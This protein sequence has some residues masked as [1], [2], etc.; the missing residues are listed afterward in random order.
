VKEHDDGRWA[1]YRLVWLARSHR[2]RGV[3]WCRGVDPVQLVDTWRGSTDDPEWRPTSDRPSGPALTVEAALAQP[4]GSGLTDPM[5]SQE[6]I[7]KRIADLQ[8]G[9]AGASAPRLH[10]PP[11]RTSVLRHPTKVLVEAD[12][13]NPELVAPVFGYSD[14]DPLEADR[15]VSG[16]NH[17]FAVAREAL[18]K[19]D[20]PQ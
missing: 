1:K 9:S 3:A 12:P 10:F 18:K 17:A 7:S 4:G 5:D 11:Y 2:E 6:L 14:V 19:E 15:T 16:A 13:E 20:I 8:A